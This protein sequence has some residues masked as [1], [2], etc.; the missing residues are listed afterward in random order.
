MRRAVAAGLGALLAAVLAGAA[1]AAT[2]TTSPGPPLTSRAFS[3]DAEGFPVEPGVGA[4][5]FAVPIRPAGTRSSLAN[6][7]VSAYARSAFVDL[8]PAEL[9]TAPN[10]PPRWSCATRI[11]TWPSSVPKPNPPARWRRLT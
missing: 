8:G 7:P 10:F 1:G 4:Q 11:W 9:Y 3:V 5:Q 2:G 6:A